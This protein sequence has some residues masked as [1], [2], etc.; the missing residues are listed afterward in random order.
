MNRL[1]LSTYSLSRH[2]GAFLSTAIISIIYCVPVWCGGGNFNT[3]SI[4]L[5]NSW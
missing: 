5:L 1:I 4:V 2:R 3:S